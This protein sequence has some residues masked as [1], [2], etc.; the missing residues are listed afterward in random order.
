MRVRLYT[1]AARVLTSK[2]VVEEVG[3]VGLITID[4]KLGCPADSVAK[5]AFDLAVAVPF[6]LLLAVY[7]AVAWVASQFKGRKPL[8]VTEPLVGKN[9]HQLHASFPAGAEIDEGLPS[10]ASRRLTLIFNVVGGQLS[11]VGP[12]PLTP[13]AWRDA[14]QTWRGIRAQLVPGLVGTWSLKGGRGARADELEVM[15]LQ[16]LREW[17]LGHDVKIV[18]RTL[19]GKPSPAYA[20]K[21]P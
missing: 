5:R 15:D 9:G 10:R 2:S 16:Y 13:G 8:L 21:K 1:K 6:S 11:L 17:S 12:R 7:V 4:E 20:E 18:I 3:G 19:A 14:N